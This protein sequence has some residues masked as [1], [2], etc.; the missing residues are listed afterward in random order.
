MTPAQS[1]GLHPFVDDFGPGGPTDRG[2][3]E[4]DCRYAATLPTRPT[5]TPCE[6]TLPPWLRAPSGILGEVVTLGGTPIC[7]FT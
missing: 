3:R 6:G 4:A 2:Q 7:C 5:C 1:I